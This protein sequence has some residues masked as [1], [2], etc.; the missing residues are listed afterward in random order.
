MGLFTST[1]T[2]TQNT[3]LI[4]PE[5]SSLPPTPETQYKA[6]LSLLHDPGAIITLN[7]L[8]THFEEVDPDSIDITNLTPSSQT[9]TMSDSEGPQSQFTRSQRRFF[10]ITDTK[11]LFWGWYNAKIVYCI[12]YLF[13]NDG[14]DTMVASPGGVSIEGT[15]RISREPV[16]GRSKDEQ[17]NLVEKATVTCPS[18]FAPF[19]RATLGSSHEEMH[20]LFVERW[21]ERLSGQRSNDLAR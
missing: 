11:P 7:P 16:A 15:W 17:L 12:S 13:V 6:A 14:S 19:I 4:L 5:T 10:R 21:R 8:V 18:I 1:F 3:L 20:K 2:H 9:T